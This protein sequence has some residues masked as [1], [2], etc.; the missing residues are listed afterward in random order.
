[1]WTSIHTLFCQIHSVET[2][3]FTVCIPTN[4]EDDDDTFARNI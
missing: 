1:M 4:E 3:V 2:H